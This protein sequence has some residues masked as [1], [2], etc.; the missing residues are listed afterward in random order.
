MTMF[1]E[2]KGLSI[3]DKSKR[4]NT[5]LLMNKDKLIAIFHIE[6]ELV[7]IDKILG[8]YPTWIS[9]L[10]DFI[11]FRK[12]PKQR[13]HIQK[14]LK[15]CGCDNLKGYLDVSHGLSLT[16]TFWV[17]KCDSDLKW[18]DVNL[19]E[20]PF[21]E[22][23]AK[24]A[25]DGGV[26][27]LE[28]S[29]TSPEFTTDGSFPKCWIRDNGE[30]KLVKSGTAGY[31]NAG[32]EPYCEFYS[33]QIARKIS[34]KAIEYNLIKYGSKDVVSSICKLFTNESYGFVPYS[35]IGPLDRSF[36]SVINRCTSM[37]YEYE[38]NEMFVVDTI[39]LNS[40][41]HKNNFGFLFD[42]GS[43]EIINFAPLFD[44]NI[45]LL[46]YA[47]E[48]DFKDIDS[49]IKSLNIGHT[50]GGKD[51]LEVGNYCKDKIDL[52]KIIKLKGFKFEKHRKYNLSDE[53]LS[54][55]ECKVNEHI[56]GLLK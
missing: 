55:I 16:D 31:A 12:A 43:Y 32:K 42:N 39:T 33:S 35:Y 41:R 10:E 24:T 38:I 46:C 2:L 28:L 54:G 14:L 52:Q 49:Y 17:K 45:S 26:Y 4:D 13:E 15:M 53:L 36:Q 29:T 30:I 18:S 5:Y 21:N 44:F 6:G 20:N 3:I 7:F 23:I 48:E 22:I 34:D 50:L 8:A 37:G 47:M 27:G 9:S 11:S 51:F 40:D 25:F 1:K 56:D 19:Y